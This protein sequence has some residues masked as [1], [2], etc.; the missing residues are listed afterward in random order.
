MIVCL[1]EYNT[2]IY[3]VF[4]E[5]DGCVKVKKHEHMLKDEKCI[6]YI[7]PIKIFLGK[8]KVCEVTKCQEFSIVLFY[9]GNTILLYLD[10]ENQMN[11]NMYM[12]VI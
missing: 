4:I 2:K 11:E 5:N 3:A 9:D 1:T 6:T 10:Q 12:E 7:K 8:S